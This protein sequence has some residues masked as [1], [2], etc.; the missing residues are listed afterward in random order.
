MVAFI[1]AA[2]VQNAAALSTWILP[3]D[4]TDDNT[5]VS[6]EVDS[7]WHLIK[8]KTSGLTG[9]VWLED[10]KDPL[11][12]RAEI[13]FPVAKFDTGSSARDREMRTVM[14]ANEFPSVHVNV[15]RA[16]RD[17][18]PDKVSADAPCESTMHGT[19]SIRG[20]TREVTLPYVI[21]RNAGGFEVSGLFPFA[22]AAFGVEDPSILIAKLDPTVTVKFAV[23]VPESAT[24]G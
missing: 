2:N 22:W 7:T 23:Q 5:R 13:S 18:P 15:L 14:A 16:A 4:V 1:Q 12:I 11:S 3:L 6:F 21:R 8:G 10:E 9:R 24:Q 17:C 20:T 19:L